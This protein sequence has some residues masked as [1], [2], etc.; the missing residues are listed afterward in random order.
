[1]SRWRSASS[2]SIASSPAA[3]C[4]ADGGAT[5]SPP[6]APSEPPSEGSAA[7]TG[8]AATRASSDRRKH[9]VILKLL[10]PSLLAIAATPYRPARASR[11]RPFVGFGDH[12]SVFVYWGTTQYLKYLLLFDASYMTG[13]VPEI[14]E[15]LFSDLRRDPSRHPSSRRNP[16]IGCAPLQMPHPV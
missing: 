6:A 8:T 1:N 12:L 7:R 10:L 11:S 2:R 13:S 16:R 5:G 3:T 14:G 4:W 15:G 9:A